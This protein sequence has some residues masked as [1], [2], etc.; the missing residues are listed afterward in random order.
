MRCEGCEIAGLRL[1]AI[2]DREREVCTAEILDSYDGAVEDLRRLG[3][4]VERLSP[5]RSYA[6]IAENVG[7]LI[8]AEAFEF[9]GADYRSPEF[10]AR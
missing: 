7:A 6:E 1:G 10:R 9:H 2:D 4:T 3:A 8:N 5:D